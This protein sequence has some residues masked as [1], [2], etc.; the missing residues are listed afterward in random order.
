M[1]GKK[2]SG[3]N[4]SNLSLNSSGRRSS[5]DSTH[6]T[7]GSSTRNKLARLLPGR[8]AR[9][10]SIQNDPSRPG[11]GGPQNEAPIIDSKDL[12]LVD[13]GDDDLLTFEDDE[14]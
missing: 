2:L 3:A 13:S 8:K 11:S 4:S 7:K 12:N 9:R 5:I 1:D 14:R 6:S 10:A